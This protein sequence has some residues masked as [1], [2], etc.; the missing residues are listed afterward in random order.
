MIATTSGT[1]SSISFR[2]LPGYL[3]SQL[4]LDRID[5]V[6]R[7]SFRPL[8]GYLISQYF[9]CSAW[10]VRRLFPSPSGV[11]HFSIYYYFIKW[12]TKI[13]FRPLP[14]YLISQYT[15]SV[16]Y[17]SAVRIVSVPFRGISFLNSGDRR[18]LLFTAFPSPSGV[19]HFSIRIRQTIQ[20]QILEFPSPSGVSHFSI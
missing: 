14:G 5:R 19:S 10:I 1:P 3:I 8:P 4:G 13:C 6:V 17:D 15:A 9:Q 2:P 18:T 12:R 16:R 7:H 11:S 20:L